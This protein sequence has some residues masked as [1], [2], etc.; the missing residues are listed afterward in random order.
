MYDI[1]SIENQFDEDKIKNKILKFVQ[2]LVNGYSQRKSEYMEFIFAETVDYD[3]LLLTLDRLRL[4]NTLLKL[5]D[6]IVKNY[7]ICPTSDYNPLKKELLISDINRIKADIEKTLKEIQKSYNEIFDIDDEDEYE[8]IQKELRDKRKIFR[9]FS[10][11]FDSYLS[12]VNSYIPISEKHENLSEPQIEISAETTVQDSEIQPEIEKNK[13]YGYEDNQNIRTVD[14]NNLDECAKYRPCTFTFKKSTFS[15]SSWRDVY[16]EL[17]KL[18]YNDS[19]YAEIFRNLTAKPLFGNRI[20]FTGANGYFNLKKPFKVSD[21]FFAEMKLYPA[22]IV[23][24]IKKLMELCRISDEN[25]RIEYDINNPTDRN[26][27]NY[28]HIKQENEFEKMSVPVQESTEKNEVQI[29]DLDNLQ[30]Y[31][32]CKPIS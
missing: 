13:S 9:G 32:Y 6:D 26:S 29:I 1:T 12:A 22:D 15:V 10:A 2:N 8:K 31:A 28:E 17:L 11:L 23:R 24:R 4:L 3:N 18:L 14:F 5:S 25:I 27:T 19:T 16:R 30:D 20:E 21:N 7:N